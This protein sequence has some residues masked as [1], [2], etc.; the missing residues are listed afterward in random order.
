MGSESEGRQAGRKQRLHDDVLHFSSP[1][2]QLTKSRIVHMS[3]DSAVKGGVVVDQ[4]P[5]PPQCT[6]FMELPN[7]PSTPMPRNVPDHRRLRAAQLRWRPSA[8]DLSSVDG[9]RRLPAAGGMRHAARC[10][11]R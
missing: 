7:S 9:P 5:N 6:A 1:S 4:P 2:Q 11:L 10:A 3:H 8:F